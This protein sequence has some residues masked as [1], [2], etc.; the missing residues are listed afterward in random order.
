MLLFFKLKQALALAFIPLPSPS[1]HSGA[2]SVF[3][4]GC[5]SNPSHHMN[6]SCHHSSRVMSIKGRRSE[7]APASVSAQCFSCSKA[8]AHSHSNHSPG[9]N[10]NQ[11]SHLFSTWIHQTEPCSMWWLQMFWTCLKPGGS[12]RPKASWSTLSSSS[13]GKGSWGFRSGEWKIFFGLKKTGGILEL[14]FAVS[15]MRQRRQRRRKRFVGNSRLRSYSG[16][17]NLN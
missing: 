7:A 14:T 15:G 9:Y 17:V 10:H 2:L 6:P 12:K 1:P 3:R 11:A 4:V 16:T 5:P 13:A 8:K